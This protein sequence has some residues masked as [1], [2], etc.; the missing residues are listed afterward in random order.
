MR[1]EK[2]SLEKL[3]GK[4]IS[5]ME[6]IAEEKG[7]ELSLDIKGDIP[8]INC[9]LAKITQV[10]TN[11]LQNAI[12]FTPNGGKICVTV[13][14]GDIGNSVQVEV[15]DNGIGIPK[16]EHENVFKQFYEVDT[17]LHKETS[18]TGLGLSIVK[19]IVEAHEG[20]IWAVSAEGQ[21][22][23]VMISLAKI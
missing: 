10:L 15:S 6:I 20:K 23:S 2:I 17:N 21:G 4:I 1:E 13:E 16:E 12:K 7:H 22:T 11:L 5:D 14:R 19:G 3:F 8:L 9:D 18:G